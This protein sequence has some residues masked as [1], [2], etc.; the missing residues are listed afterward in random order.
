MLALSEKE[1]GR[2]RDDRDVWNG[3]QQ[4]IQLQFMRTQQ[5]REPKSTK[6]NV[7]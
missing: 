6:E 3:G 7:F 4:E 2:E 1:R 5:M